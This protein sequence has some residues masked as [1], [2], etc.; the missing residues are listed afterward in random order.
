M[1]I[2]EESVSDADKALKKAFS[3]KVKTIIVRERFPVKD[4][5]I[6]TGQ[7]SVETQTEVSD[8]D[9]QAGANSPDGDEVSFK[10]LICGEDNIKN[11]IKT[12]G[13]NTS[14]N[15]RN[16]PEIAVKEIAELLTALTGITI[17]NE[18]IIHAFE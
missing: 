1:E 7:I 13:K 16:K 18:W 12:I 3:S 10:M 6:Q 4:V 15:K 11:F 9:S 14:V 2:S 8:A 5:S 17:T